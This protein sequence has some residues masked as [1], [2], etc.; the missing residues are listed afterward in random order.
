LS[1][2]ILTIVAVVFDLRLVYLTTLSVLQTENETEV[3]MANC[4]Y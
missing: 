1:C 4:R 2:Y 3:A